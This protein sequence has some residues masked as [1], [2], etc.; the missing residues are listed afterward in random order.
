MAMTSITGAVRV[1]ADGP[2]TPI[3]IVP[4]LAA[5]RFAFHGRVSVEDAQDPL[6]AR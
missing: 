4:H 1:A 5:S 2:G 6:T 3:Q